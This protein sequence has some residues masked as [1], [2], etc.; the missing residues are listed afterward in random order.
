[1]DDG[2]T[3]LGNLKPKSE[4]LLRKIICKQHHTTS[5]KDLKVEDLNSAI[6]HLNNL[7]N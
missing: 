1:M 2:T 7:F 6:V 5:F 3:E 4:E